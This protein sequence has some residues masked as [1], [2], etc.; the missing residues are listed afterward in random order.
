MKKSTIYHLPPTAKSSRGSSVN[1]TRSTVN[2]RSLPTQ[3]GFTL[4]LAALIA[5]TVL[6]LGSSVFVIAQKQVMLSSVGRDSQFAFYAADAGAE[7]AL[8]WDMRHDAFGSSTPASVPTCDGKALDEQVTSGNRAA[9]PPYTIEFQINMFDAA[10]APY[11]AGVTIYKSDT[12]PHTRI[13]ADGYSTPCSVIAT[14][15]RALQRS[16]ELYY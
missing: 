4:L 14:S 12:D 3:A 13:H 8:Y 9:G 1:G 6:A 7:C 16:V 5:S 11:C 2:A 15:P 10:G